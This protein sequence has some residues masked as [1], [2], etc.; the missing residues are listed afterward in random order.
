MRPAEGHGVATLDKRV[1]QLRR[2]MDFPSAGDLWLISTVYPDG[3]VAALEELVGS[4]G[5]VGGEQTDA[6]IFHPA[7]MDVPDTRCSTDVFHILDSHRNAPVVAQPVSAEELCRIGRQHAADGYRTRSPVDQPCAALPDT[8][9][10]GLPGSGA[11]SIH[12]GAGAADHVGD[13][14]VANIAALRRFD[15]VH[16]LGAYAV[17]I[18]TALIIFLAGWFLSRRGTFAKTFRALGFAEAV[19]VLGY[20]LYPP[21]GSAVQVVVFF[22]SILAIWLGAATAHDLKG[23]RAALFPIIAILV[24]VLGSML[25]NS[26]LNGAEFTLQALFSDMGMQQ[27]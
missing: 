4:H 15:L 8:G 11:R 27:Q 16:I 22:A 5:G 9:S 17:W 6:F 3:T 1:W 25:I 2:V 7:D 19:T 21:I 14:G 18:G 20:S 24:F 23:W 13:G 10:Y 12:D 26:L